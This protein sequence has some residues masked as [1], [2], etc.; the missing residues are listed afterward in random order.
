MSSLARSQLHPQLLA[1]GTLGYQPCNWSNS[2]QPG[3]WSLSLC[4]DLQSWDGFRAFSRWLETLHSA[5]REM[6][7]ELATTGSC[8]PPEML[9]RQQRVTRTLFSCLVVT[10]IHCF[11]VFCFIWGFRLCFKT[12]SCCVVRAGLAATFLL[13]QLP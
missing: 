4:R 7:F 12:R 3:L 8:I 10:K 5:N 6:C 1:A 13:P 2:E 11:S 9:I